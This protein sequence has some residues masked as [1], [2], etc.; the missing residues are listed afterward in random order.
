MT[1]SITANE[2][3]NPENFAGGTLTDRE[4]CEQ[5][6]WRNPDLNW[7]VRHAYDALMYL[8]RNGEPAVGLTG[9]WY[10]YTVELNR[11]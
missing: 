2:V 11:V 4:I 1:Y 7:A 9:E 5:T 3:K 10:G 8:Q 6:T